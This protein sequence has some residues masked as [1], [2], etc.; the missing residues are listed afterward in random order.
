MHFHLYSAII[1]W[2][3]TRSYLRSIADCLR[4]LRRKEKQTRN[5]WSFNLQCSYEHLS[6]KAL[7]SYTRYTLFKSDSRQVKIDTHRVEELGEFAKVIPPAGIRHSDAH[8]TIRIIDWLAPNTV[9]FRPTTHQILKKHT[10]L[11]WSV[12]RICK[13]EVIA[14]TNYYLSFAPTFWRDDWKSLIAPKIFLVLFLFVLFFFPVVSC[15]NQII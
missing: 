9:T 6:N 11:N 15:A 5:Y 10:F 7:F 2:G 1:W 14:T 12:L 13:T 8:L 3:K 4:S